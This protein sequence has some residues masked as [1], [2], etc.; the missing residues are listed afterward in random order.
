MN[1]RRF[2]RTALAAAAAL[3]VFAQGLRGT[4]KPTS[5]TLAELGVSDGPPFIVSDWVN[6]ID[7]LG[8][9]GNWLPLMTRARARRIADEYLERYAHPVVTFEVDGQAVNE[10]LLVDL[11]AKAPR[12]VRG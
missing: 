3:P 7:I 5:V 8:E 6:S 1:R 12:R 2:I 10:E 9:D 11:E 4:G